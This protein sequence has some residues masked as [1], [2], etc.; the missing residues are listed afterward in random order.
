MTIAARSDGTSGRGGKLS[1]GGAGRPRR[2]PGPGK[3]RGDDHALHSEDRLRGLLGEGSVS[4]EG[5]Q[6]ASL[7]HLDNQQWAAL[8]EFCRAFFREFESYDPLEQF[9]PF[10]HEMWRRGSGFRA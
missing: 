9:L 10:K 2:R 5:M 3:G 7:D 6:R 8:E 4:T 1:P